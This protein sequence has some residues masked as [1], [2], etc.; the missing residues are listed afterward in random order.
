MAAFDFRVQVRVP[1]SSRGSRS[2]LPQVR[3]AL[4]QQ[5]SRQC[6]SQGHHDQLTAGIVH[7]VKASMYNAIALADS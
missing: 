1:R 3:L 5:R 4:D 7:S 2:I 6:C